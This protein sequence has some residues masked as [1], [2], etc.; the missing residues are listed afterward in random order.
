MHS[1][2]KLVIETAY[3]KWENQSPFDE[4]ALAWLAQALVSS[5]YHY[6]PQC[7][8]VEI[9]LVTLAATLKASHL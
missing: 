7:N 5:P 4:F 3:Q 8:Q 2:K 6:Y 1:K 9:A